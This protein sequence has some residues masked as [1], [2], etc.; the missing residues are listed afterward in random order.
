MDM[1]TSNNYLKKNMQVHVYAC[2]IIRFSV[3][4][5]YYGL[6][7]GV[8]ELGG[9]VFLNTMI[10]GAIEVPAQLVTIVV[11]HY[12]GRIIPFSGSMI[13]GAVGL[14]TSMVLQNSTYNREYKMTHIMW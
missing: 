11:F 9:N 3:G 8:D 7:F 4:I 1:V 13:L 5:S 12:A 6:S 14:L 2:V 10:S